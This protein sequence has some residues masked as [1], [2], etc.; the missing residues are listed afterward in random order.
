[1][2]R[3][4]PDGRQVH[5]ERGS[6]HGLHYLY[7]ANTFDQRQLVIVEESRSAMLD[8]YYQEILRELP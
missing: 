7:C 1:M 6:S 3:Q 4:A 8:A 2:T 5:A